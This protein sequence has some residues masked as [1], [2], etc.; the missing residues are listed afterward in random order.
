[1]LHPVCI[2][3]AGPGAADLL[4]VRALRSIEHADV[5]LYDNL[6][7]A[8]ILALCRPGT[9]MIYAGKK[10]G[11]QGDPVARQVHINRQ[12]E[13]YA[14]EGKKVVRLKSGDPFIY[15]RA[16]EEVRYLR[17]QNIP[18]EVIPGLTAGIAAASLC[19]I[20]LTE[21]NRS[22]A[23]LFCTGHTANYDHEQLDALANMLRTGTS[24]VM[25]MGLSNLPGVLE[26]LKLA[27]GEETVYVTAVSQVSG[28][29]QQTV[30]ATLNEIEN[31][32]AAT[33][34][35]MPVVFIIGRHADVL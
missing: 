1:M 34:L 27:A 10:Y 7:S 20:P 5:V 3:G 28:A 32:L 31:R 25:Y 22:N 13:L 26:K 16:A 24:L 19:H 17:E 2:T 14:R 29:T 21:R 30:T 12:M 35:P 33:P 18:F 9:E 11:D 15:G 23:V 4:T 8:E 6:V